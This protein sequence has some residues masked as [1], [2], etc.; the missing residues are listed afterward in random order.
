MYNK[1]VTFMRVDWDTYKRHSVTTSRRIPRRSTFVLIKGGKE[2]GRLVAVTSEAS[3]K[4][5]LQKAVQ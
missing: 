2:A 5:L 3:I 1:A 4:G